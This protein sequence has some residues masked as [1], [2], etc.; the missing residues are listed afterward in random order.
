MTIYYL[1]L[2]KVRITKTDKSTTEGYVVFEVPKSL[3]GSI[4]SLVGE[5]ELEVIRKIGINLRDKDD[6]SKIVKRVSG[7]EIEN[8][9]IMEVIRRVRKS[10]LDE[11]SRK[12]IEKFE[13]KL[14][15]R[16]E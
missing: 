7:K 8:V 5:A 16:F 3:V 11:E 13:Q 4:Q 6:V 14:N 9:E 12:I 2:C 15:V 10:E 1:F